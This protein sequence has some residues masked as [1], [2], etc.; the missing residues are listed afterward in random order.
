MN[1]F[2]LKFTAGN[3][4]LIS[5]AGM[6]KNASFIITI[7]FFVSTICGFSQSKKSYQIGVIGFY[8]FEN[9][10]DTIN[11]PDVNDEDFTPEGSNRYTAKVYMDKLSKLSDVISLIGTDETPDGVSLLGCAEVENESVMK[12]LVKM[13]KLKSRNFKI[14][15]YDSP[16]LRGID[17][18]LLY[19]P[20]YFTP[21]FSE[22]LFVDLR[23]PNDSNYFT[24]DILYVYGMYLGEPIHVL[25]G[26]WPS[27]R[28]GEEAS[29][30]NRA[31]AA[32]VCRHKIDSI[33]ALDSNAKIIC[34]GDLND[35]PVSPSVTKVIGATGDIKKVS[36]G[37]MY[38]PWVG[39]Y[40]QGI[41]TLAY[42]DAWNLFDQIM[43]SYGWLSKQ[44]AGFFYKDAH[45]FKRE[46]MLQQSGR[47]KGYPLRTYDFNRYMGGYSDH[48]PTY[49]VFLKEIK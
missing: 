10:F 39:F 3:R 9:F 13:P 22:K 30:K 6:N 46:F 31:K 44:Q 28:G 17:V 1:I 36:A 47:Y 15:H 4:R 18:G 5:F 27:R 25:V 48:F 38:N 32:A 21:T 2:N 29:Q 43:I 23:T 49:L 20:K 34:M 40:N 35:D 8:N 19:N 16:D 12:D 33:T 42:N 45:I 7:L 11:Q 37:G 26:H 41:G 14:I 24:R